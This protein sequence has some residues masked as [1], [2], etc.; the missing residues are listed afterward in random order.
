MYEFKVVYRHRSRGLSL[1]PVLSVLAAEHRQG[2]N[3]GTEDCVSF[4]LP[5]LHH[6]P[7]LLAGRTAVLSPPHGCM[8]Q[9]QQISSAICHMLRCGE[10]LLCRA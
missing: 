6:Q 7:P 2:V 8:Y 10:S 9:K 1:A 5:F 3:P 4:C